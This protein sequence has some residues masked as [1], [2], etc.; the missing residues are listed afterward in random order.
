MLFLKVY[1]FLEDGKEKFS[2]LV[3]A[4]E[5]LSFLLEIA[6]CQSFIKILKRKEKFTVLQIC[7]FLIN[8]Y[9]SHN[10]L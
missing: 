9:I 7:F 1:S 3:D 4:C 8:F 2:A 10:S 5:F 6:Y